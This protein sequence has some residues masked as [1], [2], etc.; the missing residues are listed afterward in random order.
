[1]SLQAHAHA[2]QLI[3]PSPT[4]TDRNTMNTLPTNESFKIQQ[5][6]GNRAVV[7]KCWCLFLD[8]AAAALKT[9]TL[10]PFPY[11]VQPCSSIFIYIITQHTRH[12]LTHVQETS[13]GLY[14]YMIKAFLLLFH[15]K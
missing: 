7:N 14:K 3:P 6:Q 11:S 1:M 15:N 12:S 2:L 4:H 13:R 10:P 9:H 5:S 8:C